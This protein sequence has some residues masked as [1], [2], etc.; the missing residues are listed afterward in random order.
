MKKLALTA[1]ACAIG[2]VAC[3]HVRELNDT[4]L[5]A[6]LRSERAQAADAN[7][8]LDSK[9]I[10]CLRAW[11]G[12][13]TLAKGLPPMLAD[14]P[15]KKACRVQLDA[16]IAQPARNPDKFAFQDI[17]A[18]KTVQQAIALQA[19]RHA[20]FM[21]NSASHQIPAALT[22]RPAA[23]PQGPRPADPTVDLGPAGNELKEAESLCEQVQP[24]A[25]ADADANSGIKRFAAY[26][27]GNL[28][29]LRGSMEQA[30]RNGQD[31]S[32][33][34]AIAKSATAI[35]NI[36]RKQLAA[37]QTTK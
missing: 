24:V 7:A 22:A 35:A 30:A 26:C 12:D 21:A 15:G 4:Q 11:S 25:A 34:D 20:A 14:E 19:A 3:S 5:A 6:L 23:V 27:T 16:W 8:L 36:A 31:S 17:S 29:Q 18:P 1:I 13:A 37:G 33:L 28:R 10:E 32:R 9:A 2:T